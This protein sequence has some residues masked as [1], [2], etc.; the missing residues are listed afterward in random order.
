MAAGEQA[1]A[2]KDDHGIVEV[3]ANSL[4]S[5]LALM[6]PHSATKEA[7]RATQAYMEASKFLDA[8]YKG[9]EKQYI[10]VPKKP[11]EMGGADAHRRDRPNS[12]R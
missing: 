4:N 9:S 6:E 1:N 8:S 10:R 7:V 2:M 12:R 3:F 5:N 11:E